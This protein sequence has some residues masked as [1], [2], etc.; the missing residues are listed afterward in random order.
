MSRAAPPEVVFGATPLTL[1]QICDVAQGRARPQ[2]NAAPAALF[3]VGA[4]DH[5]PAA[6]LGPVALLDR[7]VEGVHVHVQDRARLHGRDSSRPPG[8]EWTRDL[9]ASGANVIEPP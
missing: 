7:R 9:Y 2:L 4:D 1:E 6:Q 8:P 3:R 5:G